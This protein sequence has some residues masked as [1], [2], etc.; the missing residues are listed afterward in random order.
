MVDVEL[1]LMDREFAG[2]Q[3]KDV[4][5]QHDVYYLVPGK[6]RS[7]ERATCTRLRRHGKLVHIERE[8]SSESDDEGRATI[9][10]F[11]D[12]HDSNQTSG[13]GPVRKQVY[14][15]AMNA[16]RTGDNADER[17]DAHNTPER[18]EDGAETEV[19]EVRQEM[20]E[21]FMDVADAEPE[22]VDRMF[23]DVVEEVYEEEQQRELPG[24]EDDTK[25][26]ILFETN[27]PDIEVPAENS[28]L[29]E[30]EKAHMATRVVRRYSHRWAVENG[31]KQIK[32]FPVRTISMNYE[33]RFFNFLYACTLYNVWRLVDTL[34]KLE[35]QS[36]AEFKYKPLVTAD[37]F[38]T[39]AKDYVGLDPPD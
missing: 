22:D 4:C 5:E 30:V 37:L 9:S 32:S 23:D 18:P 39:I 35:L 25:L 2:M 11:V 15:P 10:D 1:V 36:Q 13:V 6:M 20:L 26:Y 38:L 33:Y 21:D 19:N 29:D 8:S 17:A 3:V 14:V 34:V 16:A 7:S 27:H 31:F 24:N 28:E 12:G